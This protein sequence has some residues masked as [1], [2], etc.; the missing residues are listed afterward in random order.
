MVHLNDPATSAALREAIRK[1]VG[2]RLDAIANRL[3]NEIGSADGLE[4]LETLL[5]EALTEATRAFADG[6]T[7]RVRESHR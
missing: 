4:E 3:E 7:A 5:T 2:T 1:D 6:F